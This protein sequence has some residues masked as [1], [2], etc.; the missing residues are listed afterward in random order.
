MTQIIQSIPFL[1][2]G[3]ISVTIIDSVGAIASR[4]FNFNYGYLTIASLSSMPLLVL[5]CSSY[6]SQNMDV[7][8][9]IMINLIIAFY[10]AKIGWKISRKLK[11]KTGL[12]DEQLQSMTFSSNLSVVIVVTM[13]FSYIGYLLA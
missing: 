8:I 6:V 4:L 9:A 10:D 13:L 3:L 11:A 5:M 12:S 7:S 2:G 1:I